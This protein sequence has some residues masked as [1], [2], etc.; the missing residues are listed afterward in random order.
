MLPHLPWQACSEP[1]SATGVF[2]QVGSALQ[3]GVQLPDAEVAG[4]VA[5]N[6]TQNLTRKAQEQLEEAQHSG[7]HALSSVMGL[8]EDAEHKDRLESIDGHADEHGKSTQ[9]SFSCLCT[10]LH[11][12]ESKVPF[13]VVVA[14]V[15][16]D[17]HS[18]LHN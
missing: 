6:V 11:R 5:Y 12:H 1:C 3:V 8:E 16:A 4:R 13:R 17:S 7:E 10:D 2:S 18:H 14:E 9:G 15:R